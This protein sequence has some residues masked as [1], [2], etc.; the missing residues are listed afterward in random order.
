MHDL[1]VFALGVFCGVLV[2]LP[3]ML[4]RFILTEGAA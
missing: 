4:G 1:F 3:P 2:V